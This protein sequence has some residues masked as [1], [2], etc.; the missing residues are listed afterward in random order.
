MKFTLKGSYFNNTYHLSPI[1]GHGKVEVVIENYSPADLSQLLWICP[2]D[3]KHVEPVV[4]SSLE[5]FNTWK[6][7]GLD[8]RISS[9]QKYQENVIL[10]KNNLCEAI[11]LE[12][13]KPLWEAYQE[14][15]ELVND[16]TLLLNEAKSFVSSQSINIEKSK[17]S[18]VKKPIGPT[19]IICQATSP[20][21]YSNIQMISALLAG[22]SIILK[23]SPKSMYSPQ[24]LIDCFS[25]VNF[26]L[27]VINLIQ[28]GTE[29]SRRLLTEKQI[30]A[31][32]FTGTKENGKDILTHTNQDLSKLVT[33]NLG[34]KNSCIIHK[35]VSIAPL[36]DKLINASFI[37]SGQR[38]TSTSLVVIHRDLQDEFISKFHEKAK[39]LIIDHPIEHETE[40]FIGPLINQNAVDSYLLYMGMAKREGIEEIMR[41]KQ[42][43]KNRE[44]FYVTPSIHFA[45]HFDFKSHFL[46]SEIFAPNC[47]FLPYD[48]IEDAINISNST[49][50]GLVTS[51]FTKDEEVKNLCLQEIESGIIHFNKTT[52]ETNNS[53]PL[54]GLKNSGNYRNNGVYSFNSCLF[55]QSILEGND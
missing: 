47:T 33:L 22:N 19:L 4:H 29:V 27:G 13:G 17:S 30:K 39:S 44:G 41:G 52:I 42:I 11:S 49:E 32:F 51:V 45:S 2:V 55:P 24:L 53:L 50:F 15:E 48:N 6:K 1:T 40:P 46:K 43:S 14:V 12:T 20:C 26:P 25:A 3:Y 9:I 36:I 8:Q 54:I 16:T 28:G 35:D 23:P 18:I 38:H 7:V 31:V 21:R 37:T 5:G 10:Q 34:G